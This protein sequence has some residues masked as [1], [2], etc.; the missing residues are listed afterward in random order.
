M[1]DDPPVED[2]NFMLLVKR[3]GKFFGKNDKS[4]H[5]KSKKHFR[6]KEASTSTQYV[7]CYECG[8]QG[9]IKPNCPKLS[10][11]GGVKGKKYF[12]NKK[13]YVAW[14]D[15]EISSSSD[16]DSDES[17]NLELMASH[18]FNDEDNKVSN[19]FSI[20]GNDAQGAI[21]ELLNECKIL[22]RTVSTQEKQI[23]SLEEKMDTMQKD[24]EVDK[25]QY[26]DKEEQKS[27]F[28]NKT[29][30]VKASDQTSQEKVNKPKVVHYHHRFRSNFVPTCFYY[31]ISGHTLNAFYVNNFSVA[32][33][34]Y[35]W[36]CLETTSNIWYLDSGCSNHMTGDINKF[37]NL[38]L[39]ADGYVT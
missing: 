1:Y 27:T 19:E 10:N 35:V 4:S 31:G 38:K 18:H 23:K 21:N 37:S 33:E 36:V 11:S 8:K 3:L 20:Y 12:K 25:K 6:K 17:A 29:I 32:S 2:E 14:E 24:L 13:P 39:K 34:N 16:S 5:V 22:C 9:H 7:T 26:V 30:F 15:N 28:C